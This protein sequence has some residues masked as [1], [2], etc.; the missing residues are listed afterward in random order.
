MIASQAKHR[1]KS[2][3]LCDSDTSDKGVD[4]TQYRAMIDN[5]LYVI[6]SR[7]DIIFTVCLCARYQA[8]SKQSHL[9][10]VKRILKYIK[11]TQNLDL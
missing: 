1:W 11:G 3:L 6:A 8:N 4:I 9:S 2:M 10:S 7:P 5:L